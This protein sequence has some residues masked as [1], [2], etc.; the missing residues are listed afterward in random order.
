M[1]H[2]LIVS[3]RKPGPEGGGPSSA[4]RPEPLALAAPAA[5]GGLKKEATHVPPPM[6][7]HLL[8][9][10]WRELESQGK[11]RGESVALGGT[12]HPPSVPG[13]VRFA[14]ACD[15]WLPGSGT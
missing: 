7:P 1:E 12:E 14:S 15:C 6:M 8:R 3:T 5:L 4:G 10:T 13:L 11:G 9:A 2:V